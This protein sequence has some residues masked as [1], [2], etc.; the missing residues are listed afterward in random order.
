MYIRHRMSISD[1]RHCARYVEMTTYD[2]V[3]VTY[4]VV[5]CTYDIVR[6]VRCRTYDVVR[7]YPVYCTYDIARTMFVQHYVVCCTYDIVV[8]SYVM[9]VLH[10]I[11]VRHPRWQDSRCHTQRFRRHLESCTPGTRQYKVVCTG[12]SQ[13]VPYWIQGG[14]RNLKMVHTSTYQHRKF[15]CRYIQVHT[16]T[17][18]KSLSTMMS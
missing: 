8:W 11:Y 17:R 7:L 16:T 13:Y 15:L 18:S 4:D 3:C 6:N 1:I 2:V 5:C 10:C 12:T 9:H 14:T